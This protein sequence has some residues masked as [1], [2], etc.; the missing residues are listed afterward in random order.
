MLVIVHAQLKD[1]QGNELAANDVTGHSTTIALT[2][3]KVGFYAAGGFMLIH[4]FASFAVGTKWYADHVPAPV[5]T[6]IAFV[7]AMLGSSAVAKA[8]AAGDA[9]VASSP[10]AGVPGKFEEF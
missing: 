5:K 4:K 1:K 3:A 9:A 8:E 10:S 2:A 6:A 7:L